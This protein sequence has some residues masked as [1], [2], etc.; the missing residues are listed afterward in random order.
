MPTPAE[1]FDTTLHDVIC[2][3]VCGMTTLSTES[4]QLTSM[5]GYWTAMTNGEKQ[6]RVNYLTAGSA[7]GARLSVG[8]ASFPRSCYS[9][10]SNFTGITSRY[11]V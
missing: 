1:N 2:N 11:T 6:V 7:T 5:D 8:K 10:P 4:S 9:V 3:R